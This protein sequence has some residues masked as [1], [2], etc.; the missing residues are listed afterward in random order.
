MF[1]INTSS[2]KFRIAIIF[3]GVIT[4]SLIGIN[5]ILIGNWM[6]V[7]EGVINQMER[8][9]SRDIGDVVDRFIERPMYINAENQYV[10]T[11]GIVSLADKTA[12]EKYFA[13]VISANSPEIYSFSIGTNKGE[14]FGAR[15]NAQNE[16]E[17]MLCDETTDWHSTYYAANDDM[18][19]GEITQVNNIFDPRTRPWYQIAVETGSASFSPIYKHFFMDDL[20]ISAAIPIYDKHE[21]VV[22]VLGT[23][24]VLSGLNAYL[25]NHVVEENASAYIVEAETGDLVSST[26]GMN[27]FTKNADGTF[28]R[29]NIA[30]AED[31]HILEAYDTYRLTGE[32]KSVVRESKEKEHILITPYEKVGIQ[33]LIITMIPEE[34]FV[35]PMFRASTLSVLFS[36]LALF[37]TIAVFIKV[38]NVAIQP[39]GTLIEATTEFSKGNF[40]VRAPITSQSEIGM[41]AVTFNTM[42]DEIHQLIDNLEDKV[43]ERTVSLEKSNEDLVQAKLEAEDANRAKSQ[44]LA[45][46]SHEIRTPM[47]GFIGM[48]QLLQFTELTEEQEEYVRI[49]KTSSETLLTII[50][51]ILD[52]SKIEAGKMTLDYVDFELEALLKDTVSLYSVQAAQK[53]TTLSLEYDKHTPNHLVGDPM[54]LRQIITNLLGNAVKFTSN[55]AVKIFVNVETPQPKQG[56][57]K[58]KFCVSDTGIG[59]PEAKQKMLFRS[60]SQVDNSNTRKFGGTGLGLVISKN[61][62]EMMQG[63][64]W[65]ESEPNQGSRFYFTCQFDYG[66]TA[67]IETESYAEEMQMPD[68]SRSGKRILLVEDDAISRVVIEQLVRRK[69]YDLDLAMNGKEAV[70]A[71]NHVQYDLILMDVQMPDMDGYTATRII[72]NSKLKRQPII[73]ATTAFALKGDRDKCLDAGM[74]DYISKPIDVETFYEMLERY[75]EN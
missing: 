22:A 65:V 56:Q 16:I 44:F 33:W 19:A 23:H 72:R 75:L 28:T 46:M 59:I 50:N 58:L 35:G 3:I 62:V 7:S 49:C 21:E 25:S 53:G 51:D 11:N 5:I 73:I 63:N 2:L 9:T 37:V 18:T 67:E 55:G 15:R 48:L 40:M 60:F 57:V 4:L 47:N 1:N 6:Q 14:Y 61:L 24:M 17:I 8:D 12:R 27:S 52:Y 36:L 41:L 54:R 42:A 10:F 43:K 74:D 68:S 38:L 70:D 13:G 64:I 71:A 26:V 45:N 66:E 31:R 30:E 32:V 34:Q 69:G 29:T 20:A 39:I